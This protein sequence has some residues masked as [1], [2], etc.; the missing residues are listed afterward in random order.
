M[1]NASVDEVTSD[2]S[3]QSSSVHQDER[4]NILATHKYQGTFVLQITWC[5]SFLPITLL[6]IHKLTVLN[7]TLT[8]YCH[9]IKLRW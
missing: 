8:T 3:T 7:L 4:T 2:F 9:L 6:M 5:H 1:M